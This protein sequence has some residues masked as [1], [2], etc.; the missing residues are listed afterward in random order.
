[1]LTAKLEDEV[2]SI[3]IESQIYLGITESS[4]IHCLLD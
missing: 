3:L 4:L 2:A 1:M